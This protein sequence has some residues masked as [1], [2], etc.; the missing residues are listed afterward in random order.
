M[1]ELQL[2]HELAKLPWLGGGDFDAQPDA[3]GG[4]KICASS[5]AYDTK[6]ASNVFP[7]VFN[8]DAELA[9]R[10]KDENFAELFRVPGNWWWKVDSNHRRTMSN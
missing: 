10:L 4:Q 9:A 8:G 5:C 3:L 6:S 1:P 2:S 7:F